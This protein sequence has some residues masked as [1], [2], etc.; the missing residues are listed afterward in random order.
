MET[1]QLEWNFFCRAYGLKEEDYNAKFILMGVAYR[2]VGFTNNMKY[3]LRAAEVN[4]NKYV[5]LPEVS[6]HLIKE[7]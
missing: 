2:A 1:E 6:I 3:P 7:R 4:T 5:R